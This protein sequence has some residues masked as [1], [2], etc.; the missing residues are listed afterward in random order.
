MM[1]TAAQAVPPRVLFRLGKRPD[2]CALLPENVLASAARD[3]F[4]DPA[5]QFRV[6]YASESVYGAVLERV[7]PYRPSPELAAKLRA[8]GPEAM[9]V[10]GMVPV[11]DFADRLMAQFTVFPGASDRFLDLRSTETLTVLRAALSERATRAGIIPFE[12][13]RSTAIGKHRAVT[14]LVGRWAY[15]NGLR[16]IC[17]ESRWAPECTNWAF[18]EPVDLK[19]V[20]THQLDPAKDGDVLRALRSLDLHLGGL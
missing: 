9:P 15:E 12:L 20:E 16:G 7:A 1:A 4:D 6:L 5:R 8:M 11:A 19:I 10:I 14:Q 17:Y 18:F 3:R 13:D 2:P